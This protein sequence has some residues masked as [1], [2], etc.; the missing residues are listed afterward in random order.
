MT[1]FFL[2]LICAAC[3]ALIGATCTPVFNRLPEHWLQDYDYDPAAENARP[4]RRMTFNPHS[5]I[6]IP[7]TAVLFFFGAYVNPTFFER[8]EV[9]R[10]LLMFLPALPLAIIVMSDHLNRIIP[11]HVVVLVGLISLFGFI[12]DFMYGSLWF[13]EG[14]PFWQLLL[15]RV[16]GGIIGA[17][18]LLLIGWLGAVISRREAMGHGDVK[19]ILIC[20]LL[21]GSY[22]LVFVIFF[23]FLIGGIAAVPLLIK[24]RIRI[25]RENKEIRESKDPERTRRVMERKRKEISFVD[26]PDYIAFGPFLAVGTLVFLIFETP[27]FRYYSERILTALE[28]VFK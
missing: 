10:I 23:A 26:D 21:S 11:D 4:A 14:T 19:F 20:G 27:I 17:V 9:F 12:A 8:P 28:F 25:A 13:P 22:G 6:L 7:L 15:N 2:P 18:L 1:P 3:G 24:K 5:L 16:L